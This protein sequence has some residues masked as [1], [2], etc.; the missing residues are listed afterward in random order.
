MTRGPTRPGVLC[1]P[2]CPT[3][4]A[5][6]GTLNSLPDE[7]MSEADRL[8]WDARYRAG[9]HAGREPSALLLDLDALLPTRGRALD[10]AGGA[11]RH[12]LWLVR[13][14]LDVTLADVSPVA[15][16][17]AQERA[18]TEGLK[19]ATLPLDLVAEP[20][21]DGPWDLIICFHFLHRPL[22]SVFPGALAPGGLLVYAHPT[23]TN[24]T[25]FSRPGPDY[26]L[27]DNE[28]PRL[29][30]GLEIVHHEEGW[31]GEGRHEAV[32]VARK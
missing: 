23:R 8:K 3:S 26:L 22:F 14:G 25:R 4:P 30:T 2:K 27:D 10:A 31:L 17:L 32:L 1:C 13:R 15:L 12:A 5:P 9:D 11:G 7:Q 16:A 18:A 24:L 29:V 19:L 28:L 21:P 6:A 20:L